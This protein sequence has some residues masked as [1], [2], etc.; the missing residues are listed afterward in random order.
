MTLTTFRQMFSAE[1]LKLRRQRPLM[2]FAGLL[3]VGVVVIFM[4]YTQIRYASN[5]QYGPAGG[6]LGFQH[7]LRAVGAYFGPLAAILIGTE[8]GTADLSSGVFRDLVATGRSRL[9]LFAVRL[10]AAVALTLVFALVAYAV[11][12]LAVFLFAGGRPTPSASLVLQGAGWVMLSTAMVAALA[13]A[14]GSITGSRGV[15]LTAVIGWEMVASPLI[16]NTS[17]LGG[18]REVPLNA[19]LGQVAPLNAGTGVVMSTAVA[20]VV[21]AG[22]AA[23]PAL[24]GAWRTRNRD[25]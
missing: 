1:V 12:L 13:A 21:L 3:S 7:L 15:T 2:G 19:A 22:W 4:G 16:L 24:L 6:L 20:I 10:A 8:A 14:V 18:V 23:L 17:S 5:P 9:A 11:G 25:A